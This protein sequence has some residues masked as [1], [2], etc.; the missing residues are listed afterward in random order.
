MTILVHGY[1][2][3]QMQPRYCVAGTRTFFARH[4]M[5]WRGFLR[6]GLAVEAFEATGDAMAI[7]LA[8]HVRAQ[9][10]AEVTGGR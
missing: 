2:L 4:G 8:A 7:K 9:A 1:H 10:S 3:G 5:D 6:H